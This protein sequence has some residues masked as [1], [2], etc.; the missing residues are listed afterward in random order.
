LRLQKVFC[1]TKAFDSAKNFLQLDKNREVATPILKI[2]QGAAN[3]FPEPRAIAEPDP[4][5]SPAPV[6]H[7]S[8]SIGG[9]SITGNSNATN[10]VQGDSNTISQNINQPTTSSDFQAAI[11]ALAQ[12][13]EAIANTEA[14]D[15][16]DKSRTQSD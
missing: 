12:L 10:F 11:A 3:L 15:D 16:Y 9:V 8:M 14:L 5:A 2:R 7:T 6:A 13:K 1:T 4:I